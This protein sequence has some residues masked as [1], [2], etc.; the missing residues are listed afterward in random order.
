MAVLVSAGRDGKGVTD[1]VKKHAAK[2][3][4]WKPKRGRPKKQEAGGATCSAQCSEGAKR[5]HLDESATSAVCDKDTLE[6]AQ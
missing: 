3:G 1:L 2:P 5:A 6:N 4:N